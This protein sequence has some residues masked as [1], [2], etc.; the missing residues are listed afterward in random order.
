M[1]TIIF[2]LGI[3]SLLSFTNTSSEFTSNEFQQTNDYELLDCK[4]SQCKATAKSTG[5]RCKHCVSN[6][7]DSNCWQH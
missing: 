5:L 6:A 4:Y 2:I 7:G 3:V 1:K